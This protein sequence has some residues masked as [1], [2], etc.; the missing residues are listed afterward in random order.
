MLFMI[1]KFCC[2]QWSGLYFSFCPCIL[3]ASTVNSLGLSEYTLVSSPLT[4]LHVVPFPSALAVYRLLFLWVYYCHPSP[5]LYH[6]TLHLFQIL[7]EMPFIFVGLKSGCFVQLIC[8]FPRTLFLFF[9]G[10]SFF[11]VFYLFT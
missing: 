8:Y 1:M 4:L 7:S 3:Q 5:R 2:F 9:K 11:F 6:Y 10:H